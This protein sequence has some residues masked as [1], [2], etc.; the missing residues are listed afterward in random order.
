MYGSRCGRHRPM[1]KK[2]LIMRLSAFLLVCALHASAASFSQN[3]TVTG[4]RMKLETL[5]R[6]IET[7][8]G[9][10]FIYNSAVS[11]K[12]DVGSV[13]FKNAPLQE[14]LDKCLKRLSLTY[15]ITDKVITIT[16]ATVT[17]TTSTPVAPPDVTVHGRVTNSTGQPLAG[18][19]VLL[20]GT[21][22][23][24]TTDDKGEFTLT[25]ASPGTVLEVSFV[26]YTTQTITVGDNPRLDIVLTIAGNT[27]NDV[28]VVGYGAQKKTNLTG[29][30][31]SVNVGSLVN[32]PVTS[33][34]NSLEGQ[35]PGVTII[36]RGGDVGSDIGTINIRGRGNL[37]TSEP[38][39]VV[40]GVPV[41]SDVFAR[42][43]PTDIASISVLKDASA[44]IYGSRAAYG[45]MLVTTKK[46]F[47]DEKATVNYNGYY[48]IQSPVVLPHYLG[49]L[50]YATLLN[51][52]NTNIGAAPQYTASQLQLIQ[53]HSSNL[54][55]IHSILLF[56]ESRIAVVLV[57]SDSRLSGLI[58]NHS[59]TGLS[60]A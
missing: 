60:N 22:K 55:S 12:G 44:A 37:G 42:I 45:V 51:E 56:E 21:V 6:T 24:T 48:G 49:S 50:D 1:R 41:G 3:I 19:S 59:S 10:D 47:A 7:Q 58:L 20:K 26:G 38:M 57:H 15:S 16:P 39:Y 2:L 31:A 29:A 27:L 23:G 13:D 35:A 30:V 4:K 14:V 43:D 40:D 33:L 34:T 54:S 11:D 25:V 52:A 46:G 53:N 17:A 18:V 5:L 9:Y 28:V 8:T 32:R 36:A